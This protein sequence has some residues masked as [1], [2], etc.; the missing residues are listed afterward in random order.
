VTKS[1]RLQRYR[2]I[3]TRLYDAG[4]QTYVEL[5]VWLQQV[6]P[7]PY[8]QTANRYRLGERVKPMLALMKRLGYPIKTDNVGAS[9][10]NENSPHID[11]T[12]DCPI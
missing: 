11:K 12:P 5:G 8:L 3:T 6:S 2:L 7:A 1:D 9:I 4:P 10:T